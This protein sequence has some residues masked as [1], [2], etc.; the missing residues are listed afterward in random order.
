MGSNAKYALAKVYW[1]VFRPKTYG[2]KCVVRCGDEIIMVKNSYGEW[3]NWMFPGGEINKGEAPDVAARREV[4]EEI[5]IMGI[6]FEKIGEYVSAK[7]YK[8]DTVSV[9]TCEAENKEL[10]IDPKEIAEAEWFDIGNLPE[11]SEY[12]KDIL[13]ML[14]ASHKK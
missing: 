11:I 10:R 5:G 3:N 12:S 6:N 7:E 8:R 9:F 2:V 14:R 4:M 1:F 13:T